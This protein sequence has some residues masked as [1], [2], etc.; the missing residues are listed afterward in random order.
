MSRISTVSLLTAAT[1]TETGDSHNF[2]GSHYTFHATGTTSS[3]AGAAT[4]LIEVSN[5]NSNFITLITIV[6]TLATSVSGDGCAS[7]AP[8]R[9]HRARVTAISGTGASVDVTAGSLPK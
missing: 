7:M 5:D 4:I 6:L 2:W 1:T 8:W 9:Y 3:G